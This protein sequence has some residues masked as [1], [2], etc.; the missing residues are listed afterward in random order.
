MRKLLVFALLIIVAQP[1]FAHGLKE[2]PLIAEE[3]GY[4]IELITAPKYPVIWTQTVLVVI[5]KKDGL[6]VDGRGVTV[7]LHDPG[8]SGSILI[9]AVPQGKGSYSAEHT[10]HEPGEYEIHVDF[11]EIQSAFVLKVDSLGVKG[12]LRGLMVILIIG[13]L[14]TKSLKSCRGG[15]N[16]ED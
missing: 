6:P 4:S 7:T 15:R 2:K 8:H 14:I 12:V 10:F 16:A 9:E 1:V 13:A 5:I 3:G 11:D